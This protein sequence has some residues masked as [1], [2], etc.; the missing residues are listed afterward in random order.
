[1]K[2]FCCAALLMV[3]GYTGFSQA[4][5]LM[6]D[7]IRKYRGVPGLVYAVFNANEVLD[8][9]ASGMREFRK[10]DSIRLSDR[11]YIGTNTTAF[12]S[13][14]AARLAEAG[15][16]GWSTS[17]IKVMPELNGKTMKLYHKITLLQLL[18]QRTGIKPFAE[19]GDWN[20]FSLPA[21][22]KTEQRRAFTTLVLKQQPLL[23]IDSSQA[24]YSVAGTSIAAAMMEKITGKSWEDL[25]AQ[26]IS[27]PLNIS[28]RFGLPKLSDSL[29]PSG[30]RE[31]G[32]GL[33]ADAGERTMPAIAPATDINISLKD[34]MVFMQDMLKALSGKKSVISPS[35]ANLLL[36][37]FPH[38]ALGWENEVW[39]NL[40]T[41]Q[42]LGKS[43]LF[44]SY[45]M[46]IKEKNIGII[47]LCNSGAVS[48]K[49]A[50][51]NFGRMLRDYYSRL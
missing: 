37:G 47:V 3:F 31:A 26:Y 24:V 19:P 15:K 2:K 17:I 42:F 46:I 16:I 38:Y 28:V 23:V 13:Y 1:M 18:S 36:F 34:Y 4:F 7:S 25:I 43:V 35:A 30:H 12:T 5:S 40:H 33:F 45:T 10:K 22:S 41:S 49:S 14:L 32:S 20:E 29:Q 11:F 8:T 48:G 21:G 39:K 50:V 6:A 27:K 44:S 9:G 51:L